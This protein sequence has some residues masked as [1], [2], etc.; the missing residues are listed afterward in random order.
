MVLSLLLLFATVSAQET[1]YNY[2]AF[3]VQNWCGGYNI[4]GLWPQYNTS[5]YPSWC[6]GS[7]YQ[8]VT[9]PLLPRMNSSWN[10]ECTTSNQDF[11]SHEWDKHGTCVSRQTGLSEDQYFTT[12][13]NV[14]DSFKNR[15]S[16]TCG[17]SS[18]CIIACL[19]L[20]F[21]LI[22]CNSF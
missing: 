11:W 7:P 9:D 22:P 4:H 13:L 15:S 14:F 18:D 5:A 8:N 16:W 6:P 2:Y 17:A 1:S 21:Q 10:V 3:A 12:A 19:D 20:K